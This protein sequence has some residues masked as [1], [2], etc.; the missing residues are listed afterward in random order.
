M[1]GA[2]FFLIIFLLCGVMWVRRSL[3]KRSL[4]LDNKMVIELNSDIKMDD[5]PSY[6]IV[7][8]NQG[9]QDDQYD[10]VLHNT[11]S[12][13]DNTKDTIKMDSN[14]SYG[15]VQGCYTVA[16]DATEPDYDVTIQTNPSYN[17]ILKETT[18]MSEDEDQH[19][20]VETNSH[21]IHGEGYLKVIGSTTKEEE[22]VYDVSTDDIDNVKIN[23]NPSYDSVSGG[24]KLEPTIK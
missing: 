18:K 8:Q 20:Y 21:S 15:R 16:D 14:P 10:Y 6:N 23:P 13:Q 22:L 11:F 3:K 17:S 19:G 24:V 4:S 5:N 2:A 12:M 1:G 9:K 7:T